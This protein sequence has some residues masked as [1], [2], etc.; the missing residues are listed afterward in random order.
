METISIHALFDLSD[1]VA[2]ITGGAGLL[3]KQHAAA[4]A[5]ANASV[6]LWDINPDALQ[7]AKQALE[8]KHKG[9]I[10]V[11]EVDIGDKA[12][13]DK[14]SQII[15]EKFGKLDILVNNAG[16]TVARGQEK[17]KRYFDSFEEYPLEL[18]N[19]A[20]HVNLTGTFMVTQGLAPLLK[21][22]PRASIINIAS[23][24]GVISPDHRIYQPNPERDYPG[25]GFNT[26]LSYATSK[27]ALIH[28][29]RYWATYWAK[30]N[31]RVNAI[32]PAGVENNQDPKF[33]RELTERIPMGRM[34]KP[35]EYKGAL[36][37]LASDASSFMTG[38]NLV[39]DGGRTIW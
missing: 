23:D 11:Q 15:E 6:M 33:I 27:A 25:V 24:V 7:Q 20:M 29:T 38:A 16:M 14:A 1:R 9:K 21:R 35:H 13:I 8:E 34:A 31:I 22:A 5:E 36:V 10:H 3:G 28:M 12:S 2:V 32:S 18:W 37:F 39:I 26:P 4:L 17:F 19:L 30:Q